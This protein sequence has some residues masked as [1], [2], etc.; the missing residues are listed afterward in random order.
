V[1]GVFQKFSNVMSGPAAKNQNARSCSDA[2]FKQHA[3]ECQDVLLF[4]GGKPVCH[5]AAGRY[6]FD[7]SHARC[8]VDRMWRKWSAT[9]RMCASKLHTDNSSAIVWFCNEHRI[10]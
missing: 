6:L 8:L 10:F 2:S 9:R 7:I 5:V 1:A 3:D 4:D